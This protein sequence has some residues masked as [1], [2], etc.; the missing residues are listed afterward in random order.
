M[1]QDLLLATENNKL[2]YD[3]EKVLGLP[4]IPTNIVYYKR[5][6]SIYNEGIYKGSDRQPYCF[7]W[8]ENTAGRPKRLGRA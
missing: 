6:L 1:K 5:Q 3:M 2:T 4:K 7:V 8:K